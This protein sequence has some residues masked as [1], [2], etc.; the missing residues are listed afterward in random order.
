MNNKVEALKRDALIMANARRLIKLSAR[1]LNG[2]LYS[3]I[4]GTGHGT[5]RQ[6][7]RELGLD[8]DSN[9]TSYQAMCDYI[10]QDNNQLN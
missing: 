10:N 8:P 1:M 9:K 5:G 3:N 6:R 2:S 4:F 7:A